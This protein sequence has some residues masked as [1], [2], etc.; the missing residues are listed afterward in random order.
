MARGHLLGAA[1]SVPFFWRA[2]FAGHF[3]IGCSWVAG[4]FLGSLLTGH[5]IDYPLPG[6]KDRVDGHRG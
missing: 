4:V 2:S 6:R 3:A 1:C 5:L